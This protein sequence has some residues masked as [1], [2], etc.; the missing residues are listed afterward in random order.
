[1]VDEFYL[2]KNVITILYIPIRIRIITFA[3]LI[4]VIIL[5]KIFRKYDDDINYF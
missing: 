1:M 3:I 5:N 4:V 2:M